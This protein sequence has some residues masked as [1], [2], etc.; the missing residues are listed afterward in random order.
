MRKEPG[1]QVRPRLLYARTTWKW[2]STKFAVASSPVRA[3][4]KAPGRGLAGFLL[5]IGNTLATPVAWICCERIQV[6]AFQLRENFEAQ[7]G[8]GVQ[9]HPG[10]AVFLCRVSEVRSLS[11][12]RL[13]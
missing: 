12:I 9:P 8:P 7:L 3:L 5:P 11:Y 1:S 6:V 2:N 4:L 10:E 13:R